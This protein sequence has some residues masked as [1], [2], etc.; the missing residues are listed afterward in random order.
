M[1]IG[2][3]S[4]IAPVFPWNKKSADIEG[5]VA[6]KRFPISGV[7]QEKIDFDADIWSKTIEIVMVVFAHGVD[8]IVESVVYWVVVVE[9]LR[10]MREKC[11]CKF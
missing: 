2:D 8:G 1:S 6:K 11:L 9:I 7:K 3:T 10:L 4:P 5:I